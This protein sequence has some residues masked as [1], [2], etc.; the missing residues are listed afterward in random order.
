MITII[1]ILVSLLLPAV[2]S[3][4]E[5]ARQIDNAR[6]ISSNWRWPVR[7]ICP[8]SDIFLAVDGVGV[9]SAIRSMVPAS[10]SPVAGSTT[11][12]PYVDQQ[13]LHDLQLG[14]TGAALATAAGQMLATPL[15]VINCPSRRPLQTYP[16]WL[17]AGNN[18][19]SPCFGSNTPPSMVAKTDY[20]CNAGD[21]AIEPGTAWNDSQG[22]GKL[23]RRCGPRLV[24]RR[25]QPVGIAQL[26]ARSV[27]IPPE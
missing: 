15:A 1:G 10:H 24:C 7:P 6:T 19:C 22:R 25:R 2:Q 26:A 21:N 9:G 12:C 17:T 20:G 8:L 23:Q 16:T 13:P 27:W 3:A 18:F 4:R 11:S 14:K 5:Q